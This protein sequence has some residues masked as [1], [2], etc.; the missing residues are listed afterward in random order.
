[1]RERVK[2]ERD[3]RR[4]TA[5]QVSLFIFFVLALSFNMVNEDTEIEKKEENGVE[6]MEEDE[7]KVE[8][9]ENDK[10]EKEEEE[11][12]ADAEDDDEEEKKDNDEEKEEVEAVI[13]GSTKGKRS[14]KTGDKKEV[15]EEEPT[16]PTGFSSNRPV[17]ERKSVERLVAT[18]EKEP[19]R[20]FLV[21][22]GRGT[23]LKDIPNVI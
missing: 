23:A 22:K 17:R 4:S 13:G 12:E 18:V 20:E 1:E 10:D 5:K 15:T 9:V 2:Q 8:A 11:A 19:T 16:S 21:G 6:S 14:K 3:R 7:K